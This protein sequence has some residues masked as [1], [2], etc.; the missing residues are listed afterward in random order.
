LIDTF[1]LYV[2]QRKGIHSF[3]KT[4]DDLNV[5][6]KQLTLPTGEYNELVQVLRLSDVVKFAKYIPAA[7]ENEHALEQ[8]KKSII[9][10]ENTK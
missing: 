5:Q 3:Q 7:S 6:L 8:I 9:A 2:H 10:I 1:R 4:T